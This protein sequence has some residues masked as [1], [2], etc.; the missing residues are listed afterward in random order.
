MSVQPI[1]RA[2][3]FASMGRAVVLMIKGGLRSRIVQGLIALAVAAASIELA[4][5][6]WKA[7]DLLVGLAGV[8]F[9][10]FGLLLAWKLLPFSEQTRARWARQRELSDRYVSYRWRNALWGGL[11]WAALQLWDAYTS[12]KFIPT[13]FAFAL[14]YVVAGAAAHWIWRRHCRSGDLDI[15]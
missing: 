11:I 6:C 8:G 7:R 5:F 14:A 15:R 10:Y 9:I 12:G 3:F 13:A 1:S 2:E 4:R